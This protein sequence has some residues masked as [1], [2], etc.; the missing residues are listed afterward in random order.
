MD[1]KQ[2][3]ANL[4]NGE[5]IQPFPI[6]QF[7]SVT[8][9][10]EISWKLLDQGNAPPF[11]AIASQQTA[12]RGQWGRTWNSPPGGLYLSM[13]FDLDI[14]TINAAHL[15]LFSAWGIA[16]ELQG[17]GLPIKL[18][19][20]NDLIL[21]G[22]KLG[23]IKTE[24]RSQQGTITQGIIGIGINW[25]NP[26]PKTGINLQS[27]LKN[28]ETCLITSLEALAVMTINGVLKGYQYYLSQGVEALLSSYL[29]I[30]DSVGRTVLIEG[31]TGVII[32]V[33]SQGELK[34]CLKSP[35]AKTEIN[36]PPGSI[37]LGYH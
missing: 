17:Y 32:G 26:V 30:L 23:G 3:K 9:T 24:I 33:T 1:F 13:A 5:K 12:G 14:P 28:Q 8:S 19:W 22:K 10:N 21:Q 4:L 34:V 11:V 35:G 18:K 20:P 6:Y 29:E 16:Q 7:E 25:D 37:S 2:L 36:L 27:F 31:V 15:T